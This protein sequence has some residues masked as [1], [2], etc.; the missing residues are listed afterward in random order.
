MMD[1]PYGKLAIYVL[2]FVGYIYSGYGSGLLTNLRDAVISAE[3]IF[4]D[5]FHNVI[6]V[7][8]NFRNFHDIFDAA[9]E[10]NCVFKCPTG[11]APRL[12]RHHVPSAD[13]CG[14][15]GLKID[16]DYLPVGEMKKCCDL[17]D[18]CYDTCN[19]DKE[20]CDMEFKRCLYK[21]CDSYDKTVGGISIVKACKGAA[22][23]LFTGTLTLG[24]KAYIDAQKK[25]CYC[26]P[27]PAYGWKDKKNY[28]YTRGDE[29]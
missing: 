28:K 23:M 13:G 17:H 12:D 3:S 16:T 27:A 20:V 2:T 1:I 6:K 4:G 24:C 15:L 19:N 25:A 7:A 18:I 14:S 29:L 21:Y 26:A 22:K 9:V 8:K 5:V 10:E 11:A